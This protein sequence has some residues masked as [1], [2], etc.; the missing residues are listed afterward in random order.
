MKDVVPTVAPNV[1][2]IQSLTHRYGDNA[3]LEDVSLNI[4]A[5]C[6]AGLIGPDGVGKST[7]LAILAGVRQIQSGKVSVLDGD[8]RNRA[9]RSRCHIRIAYMPQGLGKNLY[10]TLSVEEN[11]DFFGRLFGLSAEARRER[12]DELLTATGLA[13]F[14]DRAVGALSG[15][16]KQKLGLCCA[17]IHDPDLLILDEPTTGVDPLSRR[18][19]WDLIDRIRARR[20]QMSVLVATA[21]M[22]EADRFDWLA[23]MDD[24]HILATGTPEDVRRAGG[25]ETLEAAFIALLPEEK[26][27]HHH[28][29]TVPPRHS[30]GG[31]AAIEAKGLT[32]R[33]GDFVA[34]DDVSFRIEPG[35]IFGF[36]GSNGCGKTT[37]M[38]MLTGLLPVSEGEAKLFGNPLD[39]RDMATRRRVGYMSQSFSLYSEL[40]V[41]QNLELHAELFHIPLEK[42]EARVAEMLQSFDLAHVEH[43]RPEALPL[44]IRQRLQLAVAVIHNPEILILDEPTS[45]VDPIARDQFWQY[46]ID[47]SRRDG[48]TI[49]LSTHFMNEAERCDRVSLMHAGRVL[50]V[51]DPHALAAQRGEETLEEA[52]VDWLREAAQLPEFENA[53]TSDAPDDL[54]VETSAAT[55]PRTGRRHFS[56]RRLWAYTRREAIELLRDPVRLSFAL[57][58]PLILLITLGYGISFDV[59][60]IPYAAYD[61]DHSLESRTLLEG[62]EGS[63]YFKQM[64][65]ITGPAERYR[66]LKSNDITLAIE[67]PSDFGRDLIGGR[68]PEV[69]LLVNGSNPFRAE[70]AI[71]YAEAIIAQYAQRLRP[72][73]AVATAT[74]Y[75][76]ETR[77][78]YNQAFKSVYSIVPGGYMLLMILIPAIMT[79]VG[80]VREKELGSIAN[81][82]ATPVTRL[83]FLLGKQLPYVALA[84]A[85]FL[86]LLLMGR[87][88]FHVP[89]SGSLTALL[90]GGLLYVS[91]ATAFGLVV[92]SFVQSQIAALFATAIIAVTP[93]INFS[94]MLTPVSSLEGASRYIGKLF[95]SSWFQQIST[96]SVTKGLGF[97]DL[98][99]NHVAL[100][101]FVVGFLFLAR[102]ALRKQEK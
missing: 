88:L 63:R 53:L 74:P 13:P 101:A 22:E 61:Q 99:Q 100:A 41:R 40:T 29:V 92:S 4:P 20:R 9:H 102:L 24:G 28:T 32:R 48:V 45:G 59:E 37:T 94:G 93:A 76:I 58:G 42:R 70:T 8:M 89:V 82:R 84:F 50:A 1:A 91:A 23:A 35:E 56:P 97:A 27:R 26:R 14:P 90:T 64:P 38:K 65:A 71:G 69:A 34:V 80:V 73:G 10:P 46:L 39:A 51:G 30:D 17:L 81:F 31:T 78:L 52:F 5:G 62:F 3:A 66:R 86:T 43:S 16:M 47:L 36:L 68:Q 21:Y 18:Q 60:D 19:F 6:M 75:T 72:P 11:L 7:L 15:G 98:W 77:F 79:A 12:I 95:P 33:F 25:H 87:F 44:G 57:M 96:G 67:I 83:E 55:T 2:R 54:P 85:S 49:F